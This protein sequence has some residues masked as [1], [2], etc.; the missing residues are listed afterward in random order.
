ML[1]KLFPKHECGFQRKFIKRYEEWKKCQL[2]NSS[3]PRPFTPTNNESHSSSQEL[4]SPSSQE[5][6]TPLNVLNA[7]SPINPI[8]DQSNSMNVDIS[9]IYLDIRK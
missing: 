6:T 5:S 9:N 8:P 3:T 2:D 7:P 1:D 4:N